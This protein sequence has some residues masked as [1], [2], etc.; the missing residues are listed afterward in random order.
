MSGPSPVAPNAPPRMIRLR[1][2][3]I[4]AVVMLLI[5]VGIGL[6][7]KTPATASPNLAAVPSLFTLTPT[8]SLVASAASPIASGPASPVVS[9]AAPGTHGVGDRVRLG[10][11]EYITLEKAESGFTS[12]FARPKAG[13][14][15]VS[16]L[17]AFEGINPSGA[18]YNPFFF[19]IQDADG[20]AY[21]YSAFGKDPQLSS[22]NDLKPGKIAR[23]W[24]TFE[25]PKS[26]KTLTISFAPGFLGA[27]V[28][29]V[30]KP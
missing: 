16:F 12:D 26:S 9:T 3:I 2:A 13:N 21:N 29:F 24:M 25:V 6:A 19:K 7:P 20:F 8:A 15:N 28:E 10:D 1:T 22:S 5:G 4:A 30:Y 18:S 11:E 27:P 17:F 23:G 14:V